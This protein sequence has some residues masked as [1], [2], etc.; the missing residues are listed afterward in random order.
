MSVAATYDTRLRTSLVPPPPRATLIIICSHRNIFG[1]ENHPNSIESIFSN[2]A[3]DIIC[4]VKLK[5]AERLE[6]E[7]FI[8]TRV[9]VRAGALS[10]EARASE[11]LTMQQR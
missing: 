6:A 9:N 2:I 5:V 10:H 11:Q 1:P 8:K 7:E 3:L 4:E